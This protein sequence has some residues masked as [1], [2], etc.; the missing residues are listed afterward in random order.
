M[1]RR[2]KPA[3]NSVCTPVREK[4]DRNPPPARPSNWSR[5]AAGRL[6]RSQTYSRRAPGGHGAQ[7]RYSLQPRRC[8]WTEPACERAAPH[9]S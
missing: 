9:Y 2:V 3:Q 5:T 4:S 7:R 8:V 6:T 1:W